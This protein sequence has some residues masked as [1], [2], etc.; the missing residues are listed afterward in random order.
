[1]E[2]KLAKE[3]IKRFAVKAL[4][5]SNVLQ[6]Q[7]D[8]VWNNV[9][10]NKEI[11]EAVALEAVKEITM[12]CMYIERHNMKKDIL[13]GQHN[14]TK[15]GKDVIFAVRNSLDNFF[16]GGKAIGDCTKAV[17]LD[18][19]RS[20]ENKGNPEF[21]RA[22]IFFK[23]AENITGDGVARDYINSAKLNKIITEQKNAA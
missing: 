6:E 3:S 4:K 5:K 2:L 1:M 14:E 17:I 16:C 20:H 22:S 8:Y 12:T 21:L 18:Q 9:K 10:Y 11:I 23:V 15:R 7:L 19:A 13:A